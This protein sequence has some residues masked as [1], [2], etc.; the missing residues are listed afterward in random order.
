MESNWSLTPI[1]TKFGKYLKRTVLRLDAGFF[2]H[3]FDLFDGPR[4]S[5]YVHL[6]NQQSQR[7][8]L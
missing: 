4:F 1:T 2:A 3:G 6:F 5:G 8:E 7:S